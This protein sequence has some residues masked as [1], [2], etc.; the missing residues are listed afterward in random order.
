MPPELI[1]TT[2][3]SRPRHPTR[4]IAL[5]TGLAVA[6]LV[7]VLATRAP[8]DLSAVD[9]PLVGKA[10][11]RTIGTTLAGKRLSLASFR[12]RFV[13]LNFFASW[14]PP[15]QE[16]QADLVRFA[17][18]HQGRNGVA[19]VGVVFDDSATNAA[20]FL[21]STGSTWPVLPDPGGAIALDWGVRAPPESFLI[22]PDGVVIAHTYA[23]TTTL[24]NQ[25]VA[26]A[27]AEG[28]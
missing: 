23:V 11:P 7:A 22:A 28:L 15:C 12:G 16:E 20:H 5:A 24:L 25:L 17:Y 21:A 6:V 27:K 14:C 10:A 18:Q 26:R 1:G 2:V 3:M 8:A 19:V 4:W 13:V 9:S